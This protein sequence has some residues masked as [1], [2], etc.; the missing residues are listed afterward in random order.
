MDI[1]KTRADAW[2]E[3]LSEEK[4][5]EIYNLTKPPREDGDTPRVWLKTFDDAR[6]YLVDSLHLSPPSRTG[7]YRFLSRMRQ[8]AHLKQIYRVAG[9]AESAKTMTGEAKIDFAAAAAALRAKA[10][11]ATME[12]DIK[13]AAIYANAAVSFAAEARKADEL[14]I[15]QKKLELL[16]KKEAAAVK[17]VND[18]QLTSEERVK[19]IKGI[20]GIA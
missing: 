15:A 6:E 18:E 12:D 8:E 20:F 3:D 7:W 19:R 13:G 2:G 4:R 9:N 5:W 14:K 10:I 1:V 16:E 17:A 11:D